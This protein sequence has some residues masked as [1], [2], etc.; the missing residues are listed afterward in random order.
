MSRPDTVTT[1]VLAWMDKISIGMRRTLDIAKGMQSQ[2]LLR[3][4]LNSAS[5]NKSGS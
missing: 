5:I 2:D 4:C 1:G 3:M